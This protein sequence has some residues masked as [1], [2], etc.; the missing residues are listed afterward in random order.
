MDNLNVKALENNFEAWR[1]ERAEGLTQSQAFE[2]YAVEQVL[3]DFE[4][5]DD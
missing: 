5:S 4:L 1:S 2:Y 3:K